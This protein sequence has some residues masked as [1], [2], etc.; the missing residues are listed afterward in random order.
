MISTAMRECL[1]LVNG[2]AY[3]KEAGV[4]Y[5]PH[6]GTLDYPECP[7]ESGICT[8]SADLIAQRCGGC[9]MGYPISHGDPSSLVAY[10]CMGHDFAVVDGFIIDWW[11]WQVEQSIS[12]PIQSIWEAVNAGLYK[13][14]T[15]WNRWP[16]RDYR[17][18]RR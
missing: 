14:P 7:A 16:K 12:H 2:E 6:V 17:F 4:G 5:W 1:R 3:D 15:Y 13:N 11:A 9:V 8:N 10:N 18:Q